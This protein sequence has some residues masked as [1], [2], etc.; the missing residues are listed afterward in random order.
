MKCT[1]KK[2]IKLPEAATVIKDCKHLIEL[3][4]IRT[5][6]MHLECLKMRC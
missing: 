3:Q 1:Q 2:L 4:H 6:L 5:E